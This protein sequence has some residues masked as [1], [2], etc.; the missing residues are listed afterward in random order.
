M[1]E[2]HSG[3]CSSSNQELDVLIAMKIDFFKI[4]LSKKPKKQ[5]N[6]I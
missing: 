4:V 3:L 1:I 2:V 5:N 6:T